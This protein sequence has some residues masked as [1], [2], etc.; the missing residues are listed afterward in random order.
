MIVTAA[1]A[2]RHR[3]RNP[4]TWLLYRTMPAQIR[5]FSYRR[6]VPPRCDIIH[7]HWPEWELNVFGNPLMAW[8]L[9]A[10]K[11]MLIDRMRARGAR[12]VWTAHNLK[13]HDGRHPRIERWFWSAFMRRV[14]A[15]IAL[16]QAGLSAATQ[17]FPALSNRPCFVIPHGHYRGEYPDDSALNARAQLRIADDARV[18][19]CFGRVRRY[20][21]IPALIHAFKTV[22]DDRAVLCIAGRPPGP[23]LKAEIEVA[24]NGDRRIRLH[25]EDIA[26]ERVQLFFRAAD[27]VVLPYRDILN[28]GAALLALSF[29]RPVLVPDMGAMGELRAHVGIDWVLTYDGDLD[30]SLLTQAARWAATTVRSVTAPLE[31][32]DWDVLAAKTLQAYSQIATH[33]QEPPQEC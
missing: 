32:L 8:A 2:L 23:K 25:L 11:L 10:W 12:L 19:L 9:L 21:N 16:T 18:F 27:L 29:N 24:A 26:R 3:D 6:L 28:S 30:G 15:C 14:D 13:A 17:R 20:K 22:A 1:P 33:P 5:D 7:F 4:Y 31:D